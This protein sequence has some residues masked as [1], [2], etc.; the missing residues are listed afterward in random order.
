[1]NVSDYLSRKGFQ[2]KRH[3]ENAIMNCPF[4]I[5]GDRERKFGY[6]QVFCV[7]YS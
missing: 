2:Y 3:G 1:M 7:K 6:C 5:N 4:C